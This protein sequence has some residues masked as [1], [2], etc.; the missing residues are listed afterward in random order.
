MT[1]KTFTSIRVVEGVFDPANLLL[2]DLY[3]AAGG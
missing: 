3:A 1:S 2:R